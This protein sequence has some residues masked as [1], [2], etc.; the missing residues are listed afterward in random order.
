[1]DSGKDAE[2][3]NRIVD[4]NRSTSASLLTVVSG[5][6]LG[7]LDYTWLN[8]SK[9]SAQQNWGTDSATR[10]IPAAT[11]ASLHQIEST[12]AGEITI[13]IKT[14]KTR[15]VA[16]SDSRGLTG[17]SSGLFRFDILYPI[18]KKAL[19]TVVADA[20]VLHVSS[21]ILSSIAWVFLLLSALG[22]FGF[23]TK[24]VL[25]LLGIGGLTVGFSAQGF[26]ADTYAGLFLLFTRPFERGDI[27]TIHG[28]KGKV[29]SIDMQYVRLYS[30]AE[31]CEIM[32][33]V[34]TVYK[35]EIKIDR[36]H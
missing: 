17:A 10:P 1:M 36:S 18:V 20:D 29:L 9:F 11:S 35:S 31:K 28:M 24:P 15:G 21:R 34:S 14:D 27:V 5:L 7:F 6:K 32:I 4:N 25:S 19:S 13:P 16:E 12:R 3:Q 30:T 2:P 26:L 33:P 22:S 8:L 23:D